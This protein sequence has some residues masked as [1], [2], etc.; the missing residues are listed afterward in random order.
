MTRKVELD[1]PSPTGKDAND[2]VAEVFADAKY[3]LKVTVRNHM[4][5]D[6]TFPGL[7]SK[8]CVRCVVPQ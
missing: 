8:F 5:R 2:L 3:P 6:V 1:A 7:V 4:P